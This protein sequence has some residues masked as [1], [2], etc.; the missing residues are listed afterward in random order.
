MTIT[1]PSP[2][3]PLQ[4]SKLDDANYLLSQGRATKE[5]AQAYV[6]MWNRPGMRVTTATLKERLVAYGGGC[7]AHY[8][9][10]R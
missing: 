5:H 6:E 9:E 8:I 2:L 1:A 4:H 7:M 3:G 10:I